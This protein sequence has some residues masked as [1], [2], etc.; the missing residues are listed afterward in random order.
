MTAESF[1]YWLQG[2]FELNP[3]TQGLSAEQVETVRRHL[4]TVFKN[5]TGG[6]SPPPVT[7]PPG[8]PWRPVPAGPAPLQYEST[9]VVSVP[10]C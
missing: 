6:G 7:W 8:T 3:P 1:C 9:C 2:M 5:V 4:Q 10:I